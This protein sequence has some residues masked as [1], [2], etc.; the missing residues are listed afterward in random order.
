MKAENDAADPF[1]GPDPTP[2]AQPKPTSAAM[3]ATANPND[4]GAGAAAQP[5]K[6]VIGSLFHAVNAG[7]K[8]DAPQSP[9]GENPM[10]GVGDFVK[11]LMQG[12]AAA[13]TGNNAASAE[14][15]HSAGNSGR[16]EQPQQCGAARRRSFWPAHDESGHPGAA[17]PTTCGAASPRRT[18]G[19]ATSRAAGDSNTTG[20]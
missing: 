9:P 2:I 12:S 10:G 11:G 14:S 1:G 13:P 3:P 5:T 6:G 8:S 17:G 15:W 7:L 4:A 16:Y 19:P 20:K 18:C